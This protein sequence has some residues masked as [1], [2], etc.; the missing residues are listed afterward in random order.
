MTAYMAQGLPDSFGYFKNKW[1]STGADGNT[2]DLFVGYLVLRY[3]V[4]YPLDWEDLPPEVHRSI[5]AVGEHAE[6]VCR[7]MPGSWRADWRQRLEP[8]FDELRGGAH[9]P[10]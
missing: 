5:A 4:G 6:D 2:I 9:G 7:A 8:L 1:D 10:S 3:L